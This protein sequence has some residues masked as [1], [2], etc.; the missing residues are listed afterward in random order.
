M[1]QLKPA[2]PPEFSRPIAVDRLPAEEAVFDIAATPAERA[3]LAR[4]FDLLRLERLEAQVRLTRLAGGLLRLSATL[5]AAVVQSCV[6]TLE[7]VP[8]Q[9]A[10]RFALIYG[11][12]GS[13]PGEVTWDGE[14][15]LVEPL[16]G[17]VLDIGEAVAQQLSLALDPYPRAPGAD[18]T[19]QV[20]DE[21]GTMSPFAALAKWK[22]KS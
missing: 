14:E 2:A 18:T 7:P 1:S 6:V 3:A 12:A 5:S 4:R 11:P 16:S 22:K 20:G 8:G 19:E 13:A 15:E 9:V 10:D 17:S 21:G